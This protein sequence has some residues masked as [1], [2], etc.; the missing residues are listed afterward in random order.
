MRSSLGCWHSFCRR[1]AGGALTLSA[2]LDRQGIIVGAGAESID[3]DMIA[4][5]EARQFV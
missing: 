5:L 3:K 1:V 2:Q 4:G